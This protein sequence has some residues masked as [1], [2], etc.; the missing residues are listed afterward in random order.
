MS[1]D[2]AA[3]AYD[4]FMGRYSSR[5]APVFADFAGVHGG[6]EAVDVGCGPGAL[7]AVL[8]ERLG[9]AAVSAVEPSHSFA[10]AVQERYAGVEV[11]VGTAEALPFGDDAFDVAVSQL[12]VNFM[13]DPV[14][15][16]RE[17]ARVT[18]AGGTVA[19]CV[20]DHAGGRTP[21]APFWRAAGGHGESALPGAAE[22]KLPALFAQAGLTN[23][24]E[25]A[26]EVSVEHPAFDDWWQP[27]EL[28]V[29]PAGVHL[30]TLDEAGRA[31]LRERCRAELGDG[32]FTI[33]GRAWAARAVV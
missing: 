19:A 30:A 15:G 33:T 21:L 23:A 12:V 4:R 25:A 29:G 26:L 8:V 9:V 27:F 22:G 1:F 28:G 13:A 14:A 2:V 5:L 16:L 24:E 18:R 11:H 32:P 7:T 6:Q 10:E 31:E 20:W 17:M 3:D